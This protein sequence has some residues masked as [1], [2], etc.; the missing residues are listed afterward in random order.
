MF[1]FLIGAVFGDLFAP[2]SRLA[3][4]DEGSS[5][6][7]AALQASP[8]I[9]TTVLDDAEQMRGMPRRTLQIT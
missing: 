1:T 5:Q 2:P 7:T 6:V 3:V 8:G 4:V 9:E